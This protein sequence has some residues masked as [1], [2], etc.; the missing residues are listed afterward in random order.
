MKLQLPLPDW[1]IS[2]D[3]KGAVKL[4][5]FMFFSGF[6]KCKHLISYWQ[7]AVTYADALPSLNT[8]TSLLTEG[9]CKKRVSLNLELEDYFNIIKP[10]FQ[11]LSVA[12]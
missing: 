4:I 5:P 11:D 1:G 6:L 7:K 12:V 8:H 2:F 3:K 10:L 9:E